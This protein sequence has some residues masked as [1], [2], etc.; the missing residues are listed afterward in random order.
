MD[1]RSGLTQG[2]VHFWLTWRENSLDDDKPVQSHDFSVEATLMPNWSISLHGSEG[3]STLECG[4]SEFVIGTETAVDVFTI[5]GNGLRPRHARVSISKS[6]LQVEAIAGSTS[7]NGIPFTERVEVGYP[8][9]LQLGEVT[10]VIK[11][12]TEESA[13][14]GPTA[15]SMLTTILQRKAPPRTAN[16]AITIPRK[17]PTQSGT[18]HQPELTLD[19]ACGKAPLQGEYILIKEIARGGMGRIYFGEDSQLKRHVAIKVS[20]VSET[21]LDPRFSKEAEVLAQLAHPNIVPIY[22]IGVDDQSRPFY[23]MKLIKGR[24][25]QAILNLIRDGDPSAIKEYTRAT[26]LTIFRKVCDAMMFA[27]SKGILHR[28]LKPENIMVGEYGEVLV[29]DWGLAKMLT[30]TEGKSAPAAGG[31]DT[32]DYGMTMEGE[33]MGTPQYMSPEQALGM[34]SE[35]DARSDI[36]SLVGI[37]Y[38]TLILRPPIEGAT[39]NEV[40]TKVKNGNISSMAS[41]ITH[42]DSVRVK[43]PSAMDGEVPGAL[44]AVTLKA[45]STDRNKRYGSVEAFAADIERYQSGFATTAEDAS[46][47]KRVKLWIV[48]NTVLAASGAVLFIVVNGFTAGVIQKG[49]KASEALQSLKET[50][51]TFAMRARDAL[52]DGEFEEALKAATFSVKLEPKNP[53]YQALR[54]N[55][56]QV[57]GRWPEA[58]DGYQKSLRLGNDERVKSN[59]ALT[60]SLIF[61]ARAYGETKAKGALFEALNAQGRHY[62]AMELGKE[63]GDFWENRKQDLSALLELVKE[64]EAK[65]LPVPGTDVLLSKT[66]FTVGEWKL[67]VRAEGL[68]KW[69]QPAK[70]W[71]QNDDHPVV[72]VSWNEA[73][74]FCEWLSQKT[75]K[76]WRLPT[77]TEWEAAV[78][79]T[80]YPWGEYFPPQ[81]DDGNYAFGTEGKDDPKRVGLDGI[82]GTAPVG[83]FKPNALGFYDLGGNVAEWTWDSDQKTENRVIRGGYWN[84]SAQFC[85]VA[86]SL[87]YSPKTRAASIGFRVALSADP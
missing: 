52:Q 69:T 82:F 26:R 13:P 9:T 63:L 38:A 42:N 30:E 31:C 66:E 21:G 43:A 27:H 83:S 56:L 85:M 14:A 84:F 11:I 36:Y 17:T 65:L 79:T 5:A 4:E 28:D 81:W 60:E 3:S 46:A 57:L 33:V 35:L 40:L 7:V 10:V 86:T 55:A 32:G 51:P 19:H 18:V 23:S 53:E 12:K 50:A 71:E 74:A 72:N 37:L 77:N 70:D 48:R 73:K 47:F 20:S 41:K 64:L 15:G 68:P 87:K 2:N 1:L 39:L 54:A 24:T 8:A 58:V 22:N 75:G 76:P 49:R 67:Y 29:M 6:G 34:V 78:G 16:I 45:M 59:L 25:L 44:Q 80:K 62:E 61:Q